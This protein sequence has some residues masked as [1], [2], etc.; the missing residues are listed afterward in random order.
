[1]PGNVTLLQSQ[2]PNLS[3]PYDSFISQ[4]AA[5][6]PPNVSGFPWNKPDIYSNQWNLSVAT[7]LTANMSFQVAYVGN[8]GVNLW[9]EYNPNYPDPT[10]GLRPNPNFGNI[11]LQGNSGFSTY[12]G[13]ELSFTR[14]MSQGLLAEVNYTFG[15]A[16]DD[17]QDQGIWA[18]DPQNLYNLRAERGNGSGDVRHNVTFNILYNLPVGTGHRLFR[19]GIPSRMFSGWKVSSLGI[20]RTG[21]ADTVYIGTNTYGNQNFT[22]QR[23]DCVPGVSEY[24]SAKSVNGWL[25]PAAFSMPAAGTYGN[26]ARNTFYGP[27]FKQIDFSLLKDTNL[28]ES[29][30]LEF[31]AEFFNIFNH[32]NFD[33][34][35]SY[36]GTPGFGQIFNTLGRTIGGGTSRQIQMALKFTF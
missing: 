23:P 20:F 30:D 14:R 3:Y 18:S 36:Y 33:Q 8:H 4:A 26:C 13:L 34:P 6:P 10:T 32:P 5:L 1:V 24:A 35:D 17:V 15:H 25:N 7:Q 22:N 11:F 19:T 16:I 9:R 21:I 27:S 2:V 28:G 31:R 29:R 12:H